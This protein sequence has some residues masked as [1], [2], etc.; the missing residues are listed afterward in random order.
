MSGILGWAFGS[1]A[2]KRKDAPR[3]AIVD[4]MAHL[5]ML[6]KKEKHLESQ[7]A[8]Q[9]AI[10]K[11]NVS[12]NRK[13]ALAALRRKKLY[14]GNLEKLQ[15]Q[16]NTIEQQ[17]HTIESANLNFETMKVMESGSKAMKTI[18][19]GMDIDK[20]DKVMDDI[21]EQQQLADEIGE[22]VAR[23]M[24]ETVD[25]DELQEELKQLEQEDLDE[26]ILRVEKTPITL[27]NV[28]NGETRVKSPAKEADLD[29]EEELRQLQAEMAM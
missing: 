21:M 6:G 3:K 23:P 7:I 2:A 5:D 15:A 19:R 10:A 28:S 26:R 18:H 22:A 14:E 24:G 29:E 11:R 1:N 13:T 17:L 16:V 25:E 9:E 20:V 12:S 8:E 4:L 27:P